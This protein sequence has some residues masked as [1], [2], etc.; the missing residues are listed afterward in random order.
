MAA[1]V[2]NERAQVFLQN[3]AY[4]GSTSAL[5]VNRWLRDTTRGGTT[6]A[7]AKWMALFQ[8][9]YAK[10]ILSEAGLVAYWR[11]NT[12][13]GTVETDYSTGGWTATI[14]AAVALNQQN[15]LSDGSTAELFN[16]V[17]GTFV[18]TNSV[19]NQAIGTGPMSLECWLKTTDGGTNQG[20]I[21]CKDSGTATAGFNLLM[22]SGALTFKIADGASAAQVDTPA[23][24]YND[25][26]WHHIVGTLSRGTPDVLTI[27]IDGVSK[28]TANPA[29]NGWNITASK[30]LRIGSY[31]N[32][33]NPN[34][35]TGTISDVAVYT[36]AL[37]AAQ[38]LY[39]YSIA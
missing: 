34:I 27:Y 1:T 4:P 38:V 20:I 25:G 28:A 37:S 23:A 29:A 16:G 21:D 18:E 35:I 39:H 8:N 32:A 2:S 26:N 36:V 5:A 33:G 13:S 3:S 11:L 12:P 17:T 9:R 6:N 19:F 14:A 15:P 24:T 10:H 22:A 7:T 30:K 31:T